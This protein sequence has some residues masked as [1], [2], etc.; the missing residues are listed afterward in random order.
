[1]IIISYKI[2]KE[3]QTIHCEK[4]QGFQMNVEEC[5]RC[6]KETPYMINTPVTV[7]LYYVE[8]S[9][10][11]CEACFNKLYKGETLFDRRTNDS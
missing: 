10:Q 1:M 8:G 6:G 2:D 9:G 5:V 11:L 7:R 4:I 3:L